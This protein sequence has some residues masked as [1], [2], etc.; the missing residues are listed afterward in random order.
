MS[1]T[2]FRRAGIALALTATLMSPSLASAISPSAAPAAAVTQQAD[3]AGVI[4]STERYVAAIKAKDGLTAAQYIDAKGIKWYSDSAKLAVSANR[5]QWEKL[6]FAQRLVVV[7]L[8]HELSRDD[9]RKLDGPKTLGFGVERG[10]IDQESVNNLKIANVRVTGKTAKASIESAPNQY[11]LSYVKEGD[12]WKLAIVD[13]INLTNP[14]FENTQKESAMDPIEF[15]TFVVESTST[16]EVD[17]AIFDGPLAVI[18]AEP[19]VNES[20][21]ATSDKTQTLSSTDDAVTLTVPES[22]RTLKLNND[23]IIQAGN[24]SSEQFG[25]VIS[26]ELSAFDNFAAFD[27]TAVG[28]VRDNLG[29]KSTG[30]GRVFK[31]KGLNARQY[32]LSGRVSGLD[33]SY[34]YTT[35]EGKKGYYQILLW[36][37]NSRFKDAQRSFE[38]IA[39]SFVEN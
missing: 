37:R 19:A 13:L 25:L 6:K 29:D 33:I 7:R 24:S 32:T 21:D 34:L 18:P 16:R 12:T 39:E 3:R 23:A 27:K 11:V 22:W 5:K 30:S 8:R 17:P 20:T 10:W 9:L 2:Y 1:S 36:T 38:T 35:I 15:M 31:I 26:D 4:R 28:S 14:V